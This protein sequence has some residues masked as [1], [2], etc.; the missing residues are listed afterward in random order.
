MTQTGTYGDR[1]TVQAVSNLYNIEHQIVSS[2]GNDTHTLIQPQQ[3]EPIATFYLGHF[4]EVGGEHYITLDQIS[5]NVIKFD[6]TTDGACNTN[7]V[8]LD[9]QLMTL[10]MTTQLVSH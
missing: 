2:L 8:G 4:A 9:L 1:I 3:F 7:I 6:K 10:I 5:S